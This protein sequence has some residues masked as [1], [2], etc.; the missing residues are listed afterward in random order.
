MLTPSYN[1]IVAHS[2]PVDTIASS[3]GPL[4]FIFSSNYYVFT[5]VNKVGVVMKVEIIR[6][7]NSQGIRLPKTLLQQLGLH[8][9]VELKVTDDHL[10]IH[11]LSQSRA[12]WAEQ[13]KKMANQSDDK[14]LDNADAVRNKFDDTEWKW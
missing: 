11:P 13:F 5:L 4:D 2:T 14:M 9:T 12:K 7:G 8:G 10:T 3:A 1:S 6:I